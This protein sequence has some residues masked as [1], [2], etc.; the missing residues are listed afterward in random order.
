MCSPTYSRFQTPRRLWD[1]KSD[2]V[3]VYYVKSLFYRS[4]GYALFTFLYVWHIS[5]MPY[6]DVM[7]CLRLPT[8][9][10]TY[11]WMP[12]IV[13]YIFMNAYYVF[14]DTFMNACYCLVYISECLLCTLGH[15][16]ECLSWILWHVFEWP[17]VALC[18]FINGLLLSCIYSRTPIA[19]IWHFCVQVNVFKSFLVKTGWSE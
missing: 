3:H 10:L 4:I 8:V 12:T 6:C 17:V 19:L 5:W 11:L 13:L 18:I 2:H 7:K 15:I 14:C 1:A 9:V 16:S